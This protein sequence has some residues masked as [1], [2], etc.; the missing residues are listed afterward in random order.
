MCVISY[1][2]SDVPLVS[3]VSGLPMLHQF[4]YLQ[5]KIAVSQAR[6]HTWFTIFSTFEYEDTCIITISLGNFTRSSLPVSFFNIKKTKY[7]I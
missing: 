1:V 3:G 2:N 4:T 7:F 5:I 6:L